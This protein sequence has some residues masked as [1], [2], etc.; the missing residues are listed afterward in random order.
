MNS[1]PSIYDL[2]YGGTIMMIIIDL[3]KP[4]RYLYPEIDQ[5]Q[6]THP[7]TNPFNHP[8]NPFQYQAGT[9]LPF[10]QMQQHHH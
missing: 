2:R 1:F 6:L 4:E 3:L 5:P 7:N 10:E 9:Y 8:C